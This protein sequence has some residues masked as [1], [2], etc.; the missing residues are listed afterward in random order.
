MKHSSNSR[1]ADRVRPDPLRAPLAGDN[2][3][4]G[5]PSV[6]Y[7]I[8]FDLD[9]KILDGGYASSSWQNASKDIERFLRQ[10][11]FD[12]QQGVYFG[13]DDIDVVQYQMAVQR[14][15]LEFEWFAPALNNIRM[16]RIED[17]SDLRPA[18]ELAMQMK[19]R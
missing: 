19:A 1:L 17:H 7:A 3:R 2:L 9:T 5:R 10:L 12:R 6:T 11:G 16:L 15:T 8:T 18:I 13:N 4:R 14:L